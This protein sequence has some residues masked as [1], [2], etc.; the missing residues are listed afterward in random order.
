MKRLD[1][2]R[3]VVL[4]RVGDRRANDR[5]ADLVDLLLARPLVSAAMAAEH[6]GV[7]G[8]TARRL[9]TSLGA[10]VMEVSGRSRYRAWRL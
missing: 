3:Q 10:S 2:A 8:H 5:S 9:L 6:L 1:L 7:A 4:K